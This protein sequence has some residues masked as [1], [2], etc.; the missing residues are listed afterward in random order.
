MGVDAAL[1]LAGGTEAERCLGHVLPGGRVAYPN[2]VEPEPRERPDVR[3]IAY[4]AVAGPRQFERLP[5]A[6][7]DAHLTVPIAAPYPLAQAAEAH[8][9]LEQ[10]HVLG[11]IALRI[12]DQATEE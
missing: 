10:G 9:R 6:V 2:G 1:V 4:D 11:R 7:E 5:R 8:R 12:R 3:N